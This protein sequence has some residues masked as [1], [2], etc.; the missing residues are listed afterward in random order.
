MFIL[1]LNDLYIENLIYYSL[2]KSYKLISY[3]IKGLFS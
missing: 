1:L 2:N 3:V